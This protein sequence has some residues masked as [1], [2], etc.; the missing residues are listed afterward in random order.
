[1]KTRTAIVELTELV[2]QTATIN[3]WVHVRRDHGKLAFFEIRDAS[4][5]VQSVYFRKGEKLDDIINLLRPEFVVEITGLVKARPE[6]MIN[7]EHPTGTIEFEIKDL[8]ILIKTI[9]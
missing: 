7:A 2:D 9:I 5:V 1:M 4:S 8:K 3:G 6:K